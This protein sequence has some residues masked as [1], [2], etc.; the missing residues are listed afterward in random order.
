MENH[1]ERNCSPRTSNDFNFIAKRH[2]FAICSFCATKIN[3]F[4]SYTYNPFPS[5]V[6][7]QYHHHSKQAF[8]PSGAQEDWTPFPVL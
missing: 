3:P 5:K 4:D 7:P 6:N 2:P 1:D 8:A